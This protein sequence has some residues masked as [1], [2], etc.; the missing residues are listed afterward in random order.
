MKRKILAL[1][2][3]A[4]M[5]T[6]ALSFISTAS[7]DTVADL[8]G[9]VVPFDDSYVTD[10]GLYTI[11]TDNVNGENY[12]DGATDGGI[13]VVE[14]TY[15]DATAETVPVITPDGAHYTAISTNYKVALNSFSAGFKNL[16]YYPN[17]VLDG[18][19]VT[20][21]YACPTIS[22]AWTTEPVTAGITTQASAGMGYVSD[23]YNIGDTNPVI[24]NG[25][26]LT[27]SAWN[28]GYDEDYNYTFGGHN[29]TKDS[30]YP[31][32]LTYATKGIVAIYENYELIAYKMIED[33]TTDN[34]KAAVSNNLVYL[35]T[36]DDSTAH[37]AADKATK[38]VTAEI[39]GDTLTFKF[40]TNY[41]GGLGSGYIYF[42]DENVAR[43]SPYQDY[44][45][46]MMGV[47]NCNTMGPDT[48]LKCG[49]TNIGLANVNYQPAIAGAKNGKT[50]YDSNAGDKY[51]DDVAAAVGLT[52]TDGSLNPEKKG[53]RLCNTVY[54]SV[55][56]GSDFI[57]TNNV[58]SS[59]PQENYLGG[60]S[61]GGT[62][63]M[64]LIEVGFLITKDTRTGRVTDFRQRLYIDP[65]TR[66]TS[67]DKDYHNAILAVPV[68]SGG[69][70]VGNASK[71]DPASDLLTYAATV[72][73][74]PDASLNMMYHVKAYAIVNDG[75]CPVTFYYSSRSFY[76]SYNRMADGIPWSNKKTT[77]TV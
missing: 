46:S 3:C 1:I 37:A 59:Y 9:E 27:I 69:V 52:T 58:A 51:S 23:A 41:G 65:I 75:N 57:V 24:K 55:T 15:A 61:Y 29:I 67:S 50:Y 12:I 38:N 21:N 62:Q 45:F 43:L 19:F 31:D 71:L 25:V 26:V 11:Y 54:S 6:P 34:G 16:A 68:F 28:R 32:Y 56:D 70:Q 64:N 60:L 35:Y 10:D 8:G 40:D 72:I 42:Q 74:I 5:V 22:F 4:L 7:Y 48:T 20:G 39:S 66:E 73:N 76:N 77:I 13:Y 2:L 44:Y 53:I 36:L 47:T 14:N 63:T 33:L 49:C 17:S 18:A 30:V